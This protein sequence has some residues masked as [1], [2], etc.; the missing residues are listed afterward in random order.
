[1][2]AY[3]DDLET[4]DP[5]KREENMFAELPAFLSS[6][7]DNIPGWNRRLNG[8]DTASI[9]SR[10]KLATIPVLRKPEL[11]EAQASHPPFGEFVD[12]NQLNGTRLYM[13]PGPVWEPQALGEDPWQAARAFYAAG[14]RAGDIV[15]CSIGFTG[16]PGGSILD[17]GVRALGGIVFPAGV[18][19]TEAQVNAAATLRADAYAGTPDYLQTMLDKADEMGVD[20]SSITKAMVSGGA[21]FPAMR[22]AYNARGI[23]VM[24]GYAT[25]DLGM[26][27]YETQHESALCPGMICSE[28]LIVEIVRPGSDE[29]VEPGQV[30]EIVVTNFN[31]TYPLIRFGTGDMT[32][33]LE[34]ASPCGRTNLRIAGW[35]GRADQRTKVKGMFVD[36]KQVAQ[37]IKQHAKIENARLI[38]K[39]E[40]TSDAMVLQV[41]GDGLNVNAIAESFSKIVNL[42][43]TVE[44]VSE[45]ANDGKVIDDQRDYD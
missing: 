44:I 25:A 30:G 27:A 9:N 4:I 37:L 22:E 21:L 6:I 3:Y 31:S 15:H 2:S 23:N 41:M 19:N 13:S 24:Q 12:A 35:M 16:T 32:K 43:S 34:G 20:I 7:C 36:P 11:M 39:R 10:D 17:E 42:K 26:I 5:A 38:V 8:V 18:G 40:G 1:M 45:L 29:P 33:V 14:F 28:N